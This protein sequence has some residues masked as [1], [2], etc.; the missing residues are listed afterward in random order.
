MP[1]TD[2]NYVYVLKSESGDHFYVG[3]TKELQERIT[4]HNEGRCPH[5]AKYRPWRLEVCVAFRDERKA[6]T[7]EAYLEGC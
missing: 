6:A 1:T 4:R 2:Y 3:C 7:F 5:T